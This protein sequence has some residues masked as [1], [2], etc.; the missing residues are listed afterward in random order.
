VVAV[1]KN[2]VKI[3]G[4]LSSVASKLKTNKKDFGHE[5]L[6]KKSVPAKSVDGNAEEKS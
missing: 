4:S 1:I 6:L 3:K 2:R 5:F